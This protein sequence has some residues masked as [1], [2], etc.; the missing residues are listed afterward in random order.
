[1]SM[2][3]NNSLDLQNSLNQSFNFKKRIGE[4]HVLLHNLHV[5][6]FKCKHKMA[7]EGGSGNYFSL[8]LCS[9]VP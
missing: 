2:Y 6:L 8:K 4:S 3:C 7:F 9:S 1:M 5:E